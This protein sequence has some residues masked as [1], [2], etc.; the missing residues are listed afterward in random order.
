MSA[1]APTSFDRI[2]AE[3]LDDPDLTERLERDP[4]EAQEL[5]DG[6]RELVRAAFGDGD[7]GALDAAHRALYA[8]YAQNTWSPIGTVRVNQHDP[9]MAAVLHQLERGFERSLQAQPLPEQ[10]PAAPAEFAAWLSDLALERELPGDPP[11]GMPQ[12][13]DE[14]ATLEQMKEIVA[15]RSLFFLKEPDPWAMVIPSL[16]GKAKAGLLDLLLDEYGWGRYDQMHSTIYEELMAELGMETGYDAYLDRVPWQYLATVNLQHMY[17]RHRRLCH[18]MYGY[19]YLIEADSPRAMQH[20]LKA[21]SRL[22]LGGNERVT[23]FYELH[24]T[25]DQGHQ[26]VALNEVIVP[27]LEQQPEAGPEIARGVLEGR[28]VEHAYGAHLHAAFTAGRSSLREV[29]A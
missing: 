3:A 22:G 20:Y 19:V 17:A 24:V 26:D 14:Q 15:A 13:L 29:P 1:I 16:H 2:V 10:P 23:K 12:L 7:D 6:A 4:G 8:L 21:W 11:T 27:V 28:V 5:L 9:T 18:R 25:A